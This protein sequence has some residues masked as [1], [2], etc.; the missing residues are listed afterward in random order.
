[1]L[2]HPPERDRLGHNAQQLTQQLFDGREMVKAIEQV[3]EEVLKP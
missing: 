1:M 2:R 3:Y